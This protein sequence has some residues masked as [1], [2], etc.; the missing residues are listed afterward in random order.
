MSAA[1]VLKRVEKLEAFAQLALEEATAIRK[2]L[3]SGISSSPARGKNKTAA[4]TV[5][6]NRRRKLNQ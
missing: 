6:N 5:L 2:E 4:Y 1:T 3:E